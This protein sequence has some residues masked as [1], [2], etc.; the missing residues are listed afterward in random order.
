MQTTYL[1]RKRALILGGFLTL[2]F[3]AAAFAFWTSGGTG[4]GT[5][6]TGTADAAAFAL[7]GGS[8]A[9]PPSGLAP[10]A[11]AKPL[12]GTITNNGGE[13]YQLSTVTVTIASVTDSEDEIIVG[14][15]TSDYKLVDADGAPTWALSSS[16]TVATRTTDQSLA[17]G[18]TFD[19]SG[20]GIAFNNKATNQDAC[21]NAVVHL[22]Y[23]AA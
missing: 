19:F 17:D 12:S 5:A 10:G 15:D 13:A 9:T 16:D 4:S 8:I 14:C 7:S 2:A 21:Q 11:A 20:V 6:A 1:T 23:A 18:G 3:T 22:A